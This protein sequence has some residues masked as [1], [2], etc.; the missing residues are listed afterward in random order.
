MPLTRG[1]LIATGVSFLLHA[2]VQVWVQFPLGSFTGLM[3]GRLS[4][5]TALQLLTHPLAWDIK[6][7]SAGELLYALLMVWWSLGSLEERYGSKAIL[8]LAIGSTLLSGVLAALVGLLV[9]P[10]GVMGPTTWTLA[11]WGAL[12][13]SLRHA[14]LNLLGL[15]VRGAI[16]LW[17]A[18]LI[19][20]INF[21][22]D[23]QVPKL[24]AELAAIGAGVGF[25]AWR[26]RRLPAA[27]GS[28]VVSI[29]GARKRRDAK[30]QQ[31]WLN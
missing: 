29:D 10:S 19:V 15:P 2:V 3:T 20:V 5:W 6:P 11:G 27:R 14:P 30:K 9:R 1:L 25:V 18:L 22:T 17:L 26:R 16:Y 8:Q 28:A 23:P 4:P 21:L 13:W 12:G 31:E 24:A 7:R